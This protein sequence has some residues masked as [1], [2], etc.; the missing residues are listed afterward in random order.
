MERVGILVLLKMR[1][2]G[3]NQMNMDQISVTLAFIAMAISVVTLVIF[4]MRGG[5]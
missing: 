3:S 5:E 4:W 2:G 1:A